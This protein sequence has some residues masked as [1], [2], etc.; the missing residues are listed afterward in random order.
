[1][2]EVSLSFL[3]LRLESAISHV[4][5]AQASMQLAVKCTQLQEDVAIT[6]ETRENFGRFARAA[7][8]HLDTARERLVSTL[9]EWGRYEDNVGRGNSGSS[10]G[11]FEGGED[12]V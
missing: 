12:D 3:R 7:V 11:Q 2:R 1:M 10:A 5:V 4:N 9:E 6:P 8:A